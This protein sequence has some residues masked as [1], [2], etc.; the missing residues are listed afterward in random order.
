[1]TDKRTLTLVI[2]GTDQVADAY[3]DYQDFQTHY[4]KFAPLVDALHTY[5]AD[6]ASGNAADLA[7]LVRFANDDSSPFAWT[8]ASKTQHSALA[9][10]LRSGTVYQGSPVAMAVGQPAKA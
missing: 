3:F 2:R 7:K 5:L 1:G 9:L 10:A 8:D 4:E 6:P